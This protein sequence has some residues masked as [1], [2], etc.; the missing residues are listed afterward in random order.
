MA[1]GTEPEDRPRVLVV[2]D[3]YLPGFKG[4]GPIVSVSRFVQK[5]SKNIDSYVFTRDRDL[6]DLR[7]YDGETVGE[8][9]RKEDVSVYYAPPSEIGIVGL[10]RAIKEI[11]PHVIYVN[12]YFSQT[13]RAVLMLRRF[14][15][16]KGIAVILA[17]RGEFS[18]GALKIKAF[19]KTIYL[20]VADVIRLHS[21]VVWQVSSELEAAEAKRVIREHDR[22]FIQ[23]PDIVT[24]DQ[25]E[26]GD[27]PP[28]TAGQASFV[29]VS[30]VSPKKNL[31]F[32]IQLLAEVKGDVKFSIYGP[33]EDQAYSKACREEAAKLPPNIKVE[34]CGPRRPH[35]IFGV[36]FES[37]FFLFP[38]LGENFGHV[39]PEAFGAGCPILISDQTPWQNLAE[40]HAGWVIPLDRKDEW[41]AAV[42]RCIDMEEG[43]YRQWS[44][45]AKQ[46]L[47]AYASSTEDIDQNLE[48]IKQ[49]M[50]LAR[51]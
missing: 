13:S 38:T 34:F 49:A 18:P 19:K 1:E 22:F 29:F 2:A 33:E 8:W 41:V 5:L 45:G 25:V 43:E 40:K 9:C 32:A 4:G 35:E 17:P 21:G 28:K 6:G 24:H 50:R 47:S 14:R 10:L 3:Y 44:G 30:R 31:R 26:I 16:L 42:Q 23:A 15:F 51:G 37:H 20:T 36:L 12:S 27:K 46:F 11:Q 7:P 39:V 48:M